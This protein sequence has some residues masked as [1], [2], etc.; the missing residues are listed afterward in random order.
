MFH[1]MRCI[2]LEESASHPLS[3]F[4][5]ECPNFQK[6]RNM[7]REI[8]ILYFLILVMISKTQIHCCF[9]ND[10]ISVLHSFLSRRLLL[11]Q[12]I[13]W[14]SFGVIFV[15]MLTCGAKHSPPGVKIVK[16]EGPHARG[17]RPSEIKISK[18]KS[19]PNEEFSTATLT[20]FN[21]DS[22][23]VHPRC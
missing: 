20:I 11:V 9:R 2:A 19:Y 14:Q 16:S 3:I 23:C 10:S 18:I 6:S 22:N 17:P 5:M 15:K 8:Q 1:L 7:I 4:K 21:A 12:M 13:F